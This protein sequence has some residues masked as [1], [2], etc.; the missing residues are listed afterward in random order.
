MT[1]RNMA[2]GTRKL[3]ELSCAHGTGKY[4]GVFL[5]PHTSYKTMR[6]PGFSTRYIS[7]SHPSLSSTFMFIWIDQAPSYV[8]SS[9]GK[10]RALA[11]WNLTRSCMSSSCVNLSAASMYSLLKSMPVTKHPISCDKR[12]VDPPTPQPTSRMCIYGLKQES[13]ISSFVA[14]SPRI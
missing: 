5:L 12:R 13:L 10:S 9:N 11:V 2:G 8:S 4:T 3:I 6:L 14:V 1:S 7:F